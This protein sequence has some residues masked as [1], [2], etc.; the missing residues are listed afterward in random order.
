M[1]A[2]SLSWAKYQILWSFMLRQFLGDWN[3]AIIEWSFFW[4]ARADFFLFLV[5]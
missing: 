2:S 3:E 5:R 1:G 4:D